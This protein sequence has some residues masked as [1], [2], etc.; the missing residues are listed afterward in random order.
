LLTPLAGK[1]ETL[2]IENVLALSIKKKSLFD[3]C[4]EAYPIASRLLIVLA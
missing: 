3:A 1:L 2:L 4:Q